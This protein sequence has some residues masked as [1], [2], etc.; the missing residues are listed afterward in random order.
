MS[1]SVDKLNGLIITIRNQVLKLQYKL[2]R[3]ELCAQ[4]ADG[5]HQRKE[6]GKGGSWG[7]DA[8]C[9]VLF[10]FHLIEPT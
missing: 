5:C 6:E 1:H 4:M 10:L 7:A 3:T 8:S 2:P 9:E